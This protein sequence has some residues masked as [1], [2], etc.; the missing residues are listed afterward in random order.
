MLK[1]AIIQ[2]APFLGDVEKNSALIAELLEQTHDADL[3]VL[4]ELAFTGYNFTSVEMAHKLAEVPEESS[5]VAMLHEVASKNAQYIISGFN[6]MAGEILYNSSL[7]VGPEGLM[8]C[9]RKMHLF[10]NEKDIF[11]PGDSQLEVF[12]IGFCKLGMQICFDY[13]FPEPWRVLAQEGAEVIIHPSNLLTQNAM[14]AMPGIALMNK[15][16]TI[17]ANRIGTE[18]EL[19]FN[20]NSMIL[21]PSGDVLA[22][23]SSDNIEILRLEINPSLAHNKMITSR[24]HVFDDRRPEQYRGDS[25]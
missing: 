12:D 21:S 11:Q 10:M 20:G 1:A 2:F 17:T 15:V 23:A 14:K 9:Y 16:F 19:T 3:V 7:L 24:N 22:K 8:G 5:I 13:L 25:C 4:P 6:E 18:G